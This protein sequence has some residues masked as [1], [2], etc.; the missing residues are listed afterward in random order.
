VRATYVLQWVDV[1]ELYVGS[2]ARGWARITAWW[3]DV[4]ETGRGEP[5]WD[6]CAYIH[7]AV[8]PSVGRFRFRFRFRDRLGLGFRWSGDRVEAGVC[9][10]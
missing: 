6:I 10:K 4:N 2:G 5:L 3:I 9:Y 1:N 7:T 8:P